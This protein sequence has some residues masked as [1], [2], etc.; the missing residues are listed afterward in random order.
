MYRPRTFDSYCELTSGIAFGS[1]LGNVT[2]QL[3]T[4]PRGG[5]APMRAITRWTLI[6]ALPSGVSSVIWPGKPSG[7]FSSVSMRST[8]VS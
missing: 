4:N 3:S 5:I 2:P 7:S 6:S 1:S 8:P